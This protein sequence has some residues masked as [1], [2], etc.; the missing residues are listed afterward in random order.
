M[1]KYMKEHG[2][3]ALEDLIASTKKSAKPDV[4]VKAIRADDAEDLFRT[5]SGSIPK[6]SNDV[7]ITEKI[8]VASPKQTSRIVTSARNRKREHFHLWRAINTATTAVGGGDLCGI[9]P[10]RKGP[11]G[12]DLCYM[13][14]YKPKVRRL[15]IHI[16]NGNRHKANLETAK[17][18]ESSR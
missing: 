14:K 5:T 10:S 3:D 17:C 8:E 2:S 1:K 4:S 11:K 7:E 12:M 13:S 15:L 16:S 18:Q 9:V 6:D